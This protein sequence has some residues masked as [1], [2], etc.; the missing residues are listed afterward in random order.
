MGKGAA[1]VGTSKDATTKM[2]RAYILVMIPRCCSAVWL[3]DGSNEASKTVRVGSMK[4]EYDAKD[5]D[6]L[7]RAEP[8]DE[9]MSMH[10]TTTT[11]T[12]PT[13]DDAFRKTTSEHCT[14]G[15]FP[16]SLHRRFNPRRLHPD[17][18][19]RSHRR[20]THCKGCVCRTQEIMRMMCIH[21][22]EE[23]KA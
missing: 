20:Y 6:R 23:R 22:E 3:G 10:L 1:K 14:T 5:N 2:K 11:T 12:I 4:Y 17:N 13:M 18:R 16:P 15:S 9:E 19:C 7:E 21:W 8:C